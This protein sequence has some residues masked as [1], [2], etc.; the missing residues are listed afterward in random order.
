LVNWAFSNSRNFTGSYNGILAAF[1]YAV[2][3]EMD[4][5]STK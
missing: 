2:P 5:K 4:K 1:F 3:W